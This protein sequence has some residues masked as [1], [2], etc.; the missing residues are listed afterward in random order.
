MKKNRPGRKTPGLAP[1]H[2]MLCARDRTS[3]NATITTR[4]NGNYRS[5]VPTNVD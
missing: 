3:R 5:R 2:L 1:L 4:G